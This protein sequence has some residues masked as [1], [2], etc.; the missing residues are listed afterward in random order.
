MTSQSGYLCEHCR[1]YR[2]EPPGVNCFKPGQPC[3]A[4]LLT[5][6]GQAADEL[7][8]H[9]VSVGTVDRNYQG[10]GDHESHEVADLL[11]RLSKA[12]GRQVG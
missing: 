2:N 6:L 4:D 5:L 12:L 10:K 9:A 7:A 3:V 11:A 8:A 1:E